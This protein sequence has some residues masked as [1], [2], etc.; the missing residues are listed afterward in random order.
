MQ[1]ACNSFTPFTHD[2]DSRGSKAFIRICLC[3]CVCVC[4]FVRTIEPKWLKLQSPKLLHGWVVA[5]HLILKSQKV[6]GQC[7][8]V[9]NYENKKTIRRNSNGND[10]KDI[11][12]QREGNLTLQTQVLDNYTENDRPLQVFY[13]EMLT[14]IVNIGPKKS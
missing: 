8:R 5:T 6:K 1:L 13:Q 9:T 14:M 12:L 7:H 3:V 10:S 2:D 4:W 11:Q